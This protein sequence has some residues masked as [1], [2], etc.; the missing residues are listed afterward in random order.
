MVGLAKEFEQ[1]EWKP[2]N[3]SPN[4]KIQHKL[5]NGIYDLIAVC[6]ICSDSWIQMFH[7][8]QPE[9]NQITHKL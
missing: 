6:M 7:H 1:I 2:P 9:A 4:M 8:N 5:F 3:K